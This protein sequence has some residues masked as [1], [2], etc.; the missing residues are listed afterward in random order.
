MVMN[1]IKIFLTTSSYCEY[2]YN[3]EQ[4]IMDG[5]PLVSFDL[6]ILTGEVYVPWLIDSCTIDVDS[7]DYREYI[8]IQTNKTIVQWSMK[9]CGKNNINCASV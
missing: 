6:P 1:I 3:G 9:G 8:I 7:K 2:Y 5:I 4:C